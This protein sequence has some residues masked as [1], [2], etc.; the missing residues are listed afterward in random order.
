MQALNS[1]F[2]FRS[3]FLLACLVMQG[4]ALA[5]NC[6]GMAA[7]FDPV[8]RVVCLPSVEVIEGN[9]K[10]S[11]V[12]ELLNFNPAEPLRFGLATANPIAATTSY[13]ASY[14]SANGVLQ[15]PAVEIRNGFGVE[16]YRV[17][18]NLG[19]DS[20]FAVTS[21]AAVISPDYQPEK[22]WKPY[23]G[24]LPNE[25]HAVNI[26]EQSLPYAALANAVYD[27]AITK[28]GD[29]LLLESVSRSSGMQAAVYQNMQTQELVLAF[30]GTEFC[31]V[32][33]FS[34]SLSDIKES[35]KDTLADTLLTQGRDSGQFDD[36]YNYARDM[37][38]KYP[39]KIKSIT[40]HSLGG[41]LAQA[42]GAA[43]KIQT[44]AFNSS[45]VANNY[46]DQHG[47]KAK[48]PSYAD[49]IFVLSDV[50]DPVSNTDELGKI[51]A[52]AAHVAPLLQYDFD[53]KAVLPTYNVTLDSLRFNKHGIVK[54][55]DN[56]SQLTT[57]YRNGW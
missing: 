25:K 52:D 35:G 30:R 57:I 45:P 13:S 43:A 24:L 51:Y 19:K 50:H 23:V 20:V 5:A 42:V 44:F 53:K 27:F 33:S 18:L 29:W 14:V 21:I 16:R 4:S 6:T 15:I 46:F 56:I 3:P 11:Y 17:S 9:T 37:L 36:A 7:V 49:Y 47:V 41:G 38:L 55:L 10:Q 39:D 12:A 54:L 28:V 2:S 48:D 8:S 31:D 26:L 34:C 40:G 22:T 32:L 1:N